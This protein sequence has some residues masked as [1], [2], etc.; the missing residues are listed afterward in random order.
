MRPSRR[1]CLFASLALLALSLLAPRT[2]AETLTIT[3]SPPG[4]TVE[5]DGLVVGKTPYRIKY[6]GGYFH[7]THTVFG[8]RLEHSMTLRVY[9]DGYTPQEIALTE[10]PYEWVALNGRSHGHYWLLKTNEIHATLEQASTVFD[11]SV[12]ISVAAANGVE[13]RPEIS[14][15]QLVEAATPAVVKL[16]DADGWGTGFLLTD[17]GVIATNHH[18]T[19]GKVSM[20]VIFSDGTELLGKIVY[21]DPRLDLAFVKVEGAGFAHLALADIS[22]VRQGQTVIAIGNP[23][24]G[25]PNTITRGVVSAVGQDRQAGPGTWIQTDAAIN[26]G[27]SG[28]P[29][30]NTHGEVVGITT[31][32]E[33][34]SSDDRPLQG[35]GFALSSEDLL[36]LLR[37]FYPE[38][39]SVS[40]AP[41]VVPA[42]NG[43]VTIASDPPGADIYIDGKFVGQTPSTIQLPSGTHRIEVKSRGKQ[44]WQ[45]DLEVLKDSQLTLHP[46]LES[47]P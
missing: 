17:T 39:V 19:A 45:R 3:S 46:V 23:D 21:T 20:D 11:G 26:P 6:P 40:Q 8:E 22:Q 36:K 14:T 32:K 18:V 29:L 9:K 13:L 35:I 27:N 37:R 7:K 24:H 10:G 16:R 31:Q 28:G 33:F 42:G 47:S 44:D 34:I 5:I 1:H 30:L 25:L 43:S 38:T 12:H 2:R 4:A 41:T 15:E